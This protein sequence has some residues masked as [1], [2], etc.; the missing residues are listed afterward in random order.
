MLLT[1]DNVLT[2]DQ[3]KQVMTILNASDFI[4]GKATT[5]G[6]S[7]MVKDNLQVPQNDPQVQ[8]IM[9]LVMETVSNNQQFF[10]TVYP[11]RLFPPI[12]NRYEAGMSYGKHVDN[13]LM[14]MPQ[15]IRTDVAFTLFISEPNSYE[16]GELIIQIPGRG[17][18]HVKLPAGSLIV[19]EPNH[20]HWVAPVTEGIRYAAV[21]W[22]ESLVR[23]DRQRAILTELDRTAI[24]LQAKLPDSPELNAVIDSFHNLMRMWSEP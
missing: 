12:F 2:G 22:A 17:E 13:A 14:Q 19:Y 20:P 9:K 24:S 15:P 5:S 6:L 21:S 10:T 1:I 3:L 8:S 7:A 23:D 4:S 18:E 11:K 16:G